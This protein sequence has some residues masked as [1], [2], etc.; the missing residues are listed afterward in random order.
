MRIANPTPQTKEDLMNAA[1]RLMIAKGYEGTTVDEICEAA[2]VTKGSFFHYFKSKEDLAGRL[3]KRFAEGAGRVMKEAG[4]CE[5]DD[6]LDR[7]YAYVDCAIR[8]ARDP[9]F[10][11]CLI[12]TF[13]QEM[14]ETHS[15]FRSLCAESFQQ[16]AVFLR[17]DFVKAKAKYA[18]KASFD[19][20]GLADYFIAVSQGSFLMKKVTRDGK[21]LERNLRLLKQHIRSLYGK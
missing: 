3:I 1:T 18:P 2:K 16:M 13:S 9:D 10:K 17:E 12:G 20:A 15:G 8:M 4:C 19:A 5:G 14:A 11:G 6:P 7:I 21:V